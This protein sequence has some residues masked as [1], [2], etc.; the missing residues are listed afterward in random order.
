VE[1]F[2]TKSVVL[3][4]VDTRDADRVVTLFSE[5]RG[6][7]S[8]YAAGARKSRQRFAGA[9]EPFTLVVAHLT[10][11]RTEMHRFEKAD[12][13]ESFGGIR[14]ELSAI[15][16]ASCACELVRELCRDR[17]PHPEVFGE[18]VDLLFRLSRGAGRA[19]DLL[20]FELLALGWAGLRPHLQDCARCG[21]DPIPS[22]WFEP[23]LGGLL[24]AACA[25]Q[26]P[27]SMSLRPG[28]AEGLRRLQGG[29]RSPLEDLA[30]REAS[31]H[32]TRFVTHHLGRSLRSFEMLRTLGVE[33]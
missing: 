6:R 26:T 18:L 10:E 20:A 29:D 27:G 14:L 2:A 11:T 12:V 1:R 21:S 17:S 3:G 5:D 9:L 7:I 13:V 28:V 19:E 32:L 22:A 31:F 8:A 24:C 16:R 33:L 15:A 4:T 23:D 30:R 25:R